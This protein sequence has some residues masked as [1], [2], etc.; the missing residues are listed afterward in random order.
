MTRRGRKALFAMLSALRLV[1]GSKH[2]PHAFDSVTWQAAALSDRNQPARAQ[3]EI[4]E[5][6]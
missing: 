6:T 4:S 1:A 3:S 5:L 2:T